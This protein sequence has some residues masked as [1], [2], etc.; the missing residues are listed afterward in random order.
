MNTSKQKSRQKTRGSESE[1]P[2]DALKRYEFI[3][4]SKFADMNCEHDWLIEGIL[5]EGQAGVIG[6]PAKC[7]KT[8]LVIDMA[9][10][11]G[12]GEPFLGEFH[13]PLAC[14]VAVM[15]GESGKSSLKDTAKRISLSK[16]LSL[17]EIPKVYWAFTLPN[18]SDQDDLLRLGEFLEWRKIKVVFIDP[19][20]L[21]LTGGGRGVSPTNVYEVGPILSRMTETC[22]KAGAT[23]IIV[24]QTIKSA[25]KPSENASVGLYDLAFSGVSEFFRQW[26]LLGK[27]EEF[28][29]SQG[30]HQIRMSVGG[31]A[32]HSGDW[33]VDV[34]EGVMDNNFLGREWDVDVWMRPVYNPEDPGNE[35]E[36]DDSF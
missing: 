13:V 31:S 20:Y 7:L 2:A 30:L 32:G 26:V 34:K 36:S 22:L 21:C 24:H 25:A 28:I 33:N 17:S 14:R 4:S 29:Q 12:S 27:R 19:L 9:L 5:V 6:G 11:L 23:P 3:Q 15:S 18:L 10:S 1:R 35:I 8:G 16:E